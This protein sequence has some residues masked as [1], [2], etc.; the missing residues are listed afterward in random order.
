MANII[1]AWLAYIP[2]SFLDFFF[3]PTGQTFGDCTSPSNW[4]SFEKAHSELAQSL[5]ASPTTISRVQAHLPPLSTYASPLPADVAS[6]TPAYA[7]SQN[8]GIFRPDG[9]RRPLHIPTML[10]ITF[11]STLVI[12]LPLLS[13]S[14]RCI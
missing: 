7:D 3:P 12:T 13:S 11:M 4:D 14:L 2:F 6:F 8:P 9:S 10:I 5:W 1:P